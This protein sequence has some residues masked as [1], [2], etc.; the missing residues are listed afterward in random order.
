[1]GGGGSDTSDYV[2]VTALASPSRSHGVTQ[3]PSY[4]EAIQSVQTQRQMTCTAKPLPGLQK[5]P[6]EQFRWR[7]G[8]IPGSDSGTGSRALPSRVLHKQTMLCSGS[9]AAANRGTQKE[10]S[11]TQAEPTRLQDHHAGTATCEGTSDKR[12]H[13]APHPPLTTLLSC[14]DLNG[15]TTPWIGVK[16][17]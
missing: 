2:G 9:N 15:H 5:E 11:S 1:M 7:Q 14:K 13:P 8:R 10:P 3:E 6:G 4:E 17:G 16:L 12:S